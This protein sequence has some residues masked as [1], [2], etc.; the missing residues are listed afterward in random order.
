M[1]RPH[2]WAAPGYKVR[3]RRGCGERHTGRKPSLDGEVR[4]NL[5]MTFG[6]LITLREEGTGLLPVKSQKGA[7]WEPGHQYCLSLVF[8]P[9]ELELRVWIQVILSLGGQLRKPE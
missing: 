2:C 3:K 1:K 8:L 7:P 5:G 6:R 4:Q 9:A